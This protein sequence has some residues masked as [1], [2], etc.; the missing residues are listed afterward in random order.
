MAG[1][2][3][4]ATEEAPRGTGAYPRAV[5]AAGFVL[6]A[7]QGPLDPATPSIR[8]TTIEEQTRSTP[9]N[10]AAGPPD[11]LVEIDAVLSLPSPEP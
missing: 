3:R 6:I 2:E 10:V 9:D 5:R 7:A 4:I 11:I 8:G 1:H